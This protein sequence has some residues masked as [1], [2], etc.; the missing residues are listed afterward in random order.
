VNTLA[1]EDP[2]TDLNLAEARLNLSA[3]RA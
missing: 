1:Q 3:V 2:T